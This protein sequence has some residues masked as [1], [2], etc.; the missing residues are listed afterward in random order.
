MKNLRSLSTFL[1][2]L[3]TT[4]PGFCGV[5]ELP[6]PDMK[7]GAGALD[8]AVAEQVREND[9]V[10]ELPHGRPAE[11]IRDK[12]NTLDNAKAYAG[13]P[14]GGRGTNSGKTV[15][16]PAGFVNTGS[17]AS[18][19]MKKD[20]RA[21]FKDA[22]IADGPTSLA[23]KVMD[24]IGWKEG[25]SGNGA[26]VTLLFQVPNKGGATGRVI[27][28]SQD[29]VVTLKNG[30][31][32]R[33]LSTTE[34]AAPAQVAAQRPNA[35]AAPAQQGK[36]GAAPALEEKVL[37]PGQE[38]GMNPEPHRDDSRLKLPGAPAAPEPKVKA[39]EAQA[40]RPAA[41]AA[42]QAIAKVDMPKAA[43]VEV[44][45]DTRNTLDNAN[46]YAGVPVGGRSANVG[47]TIELPA[48]FVNTG[49]LV[50]P[51]MK[52]DLRAAFHDAAIAGG[53]ASVAYKTMDAIG[54][55]EG[56]SGNGAEIT[57][58]FQVPN[59]SGDS[60]RSIDTNKSHGD[61]IALNNG[62]AFHVINVAAA[63]AAKPA[64]EPRAKPAA[65]QEAAGE[66]AM[67]PWS[68]VPNT[69]VVGAMPPKVAAAMENLRTVLFRSLMPAFN[70]QWTLTWKVGSH[71]E[72]A[73]R[74][75]SVATKDPKSDRALADI[76]QKLGAMGYIASEGRFNRAL[77]TEDLRAVFNSLN[78]LDYR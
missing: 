60:G 2:F 71:L 9:P 48:A 61:V 74:E 4:S 57:V 56:D 75:A 38:W 36:P 23:H 12:A 34:D 33:V 62:A 26:K 59:K 22:A 41:E 28:K 18:P 69:P 54:W 43:G 73:L 3:I 44:H 64:A 31:A 52:N 32:F 1:S 24:A 11:S 72:G 68:L 49:S 78:R 42:P 51:Q 15:D 40:A 17:L 10:Q 70:D 25:D 53:P 35:A 14:V 65:V 63:P 8:T 30:A 7:P 47:K 5:M 13:V 37:A 76:K 46:A 55:K 50:S 16:L 6:P 39:V 20:L 21:A 29:G 77:S 19:Q 45:R 58:L 66:P 27:E 67:N